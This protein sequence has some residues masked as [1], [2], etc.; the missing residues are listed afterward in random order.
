M[1]KMVKKV[2]LITCECGDGEDSLLLL[3]TGVEQS[4]RDTCFIYESKEKQDGKSACDSWSNKVNNYY[5]SYT[6]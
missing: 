2:C 4:C 6:E 1:G 3:E 5:G